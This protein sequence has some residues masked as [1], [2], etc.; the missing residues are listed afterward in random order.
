MFA[1]DGGGAGDDPYNF[2]ISHSFSNRDTKKKGSEKTVGSKLS[3]ERSVQSRLG[4]SSLN[5]TVRPDPKSSPLKRQVGE[6]LATNF[7][8]R[9]I[10]NVFYICASIGLE[11]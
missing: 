2:D 7:A 3:S 9:F 4:K 11:Y 6:N 8:N 1:R 5:K 10:Q